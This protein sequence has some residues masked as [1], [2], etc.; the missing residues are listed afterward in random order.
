MAAEPHGW[1]RIETSGN[2][3]EE[4]VNDFLPGMS[5]A[6]VSWRDKKARR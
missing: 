6:P 4:I 2:C 5:A 3:Y 1:K